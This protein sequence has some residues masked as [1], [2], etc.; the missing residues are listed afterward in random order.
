MVSLCLV[1]VASPLSPG[2]TV[3]LT[4]PWFSPP[5]PPP[6]SR[7]ASGPESPPATSVLSRVSGGLIS[8]P[9]L[10]T[11]ALILLCPLTAL[12]INSAKSPGDDAS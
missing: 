9:V 7:W 3:A 10:C 2:L 12:L 11:K 1:H 5:Y 6:A 8:N 4:G